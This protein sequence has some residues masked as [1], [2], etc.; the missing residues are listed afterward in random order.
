MG[1]AQSRSLLRHPQPK[2]DRFEREEVKG[3]HV[4]VQTLRHGTRHRTL[5]QDPHA[6]NQ[7][8]SQEK[9]GSDDK[10]LMSEYTSFGGWESGSF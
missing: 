9:C 8:P 3:C 2:V 10:I 4:L 1:S 5:R 6:G 7:E